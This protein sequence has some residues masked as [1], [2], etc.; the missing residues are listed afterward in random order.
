M[1]IVML[2]GLSASIISL[3]SFGSAH[4]YVGA[5]LARLIPSFL[6]GTPV[7]IKSMMGD[8]C[9]SIGQAKAMTIFN[10]GHGLGAVIGETFEDLQGSFC[11]ASIAKF[12]SH[13]VM[14]G[15]YLPISMQPSCPDTKGLSYA[16]QGLSVICQA[17]HHYKK[18]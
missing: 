15:Y 3:L 8:S 11:I 6:I 13:K 4:T 7:A 17:V 2:V 14:P 16:F 10:L 12:Q 1:Q 18:N 9:D 5:I